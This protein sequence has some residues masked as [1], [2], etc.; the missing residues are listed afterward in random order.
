MGRFQI[1]VA[2][3]AQTSQNAAP[4]GIAITSAALFG[5]AFANAA[6]ALKGNDRRCSRI[7]ETLKISAS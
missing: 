3:G 4:Y 6:A 1:G 5:R 2:V 7:F